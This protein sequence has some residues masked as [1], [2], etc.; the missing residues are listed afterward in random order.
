MMG[1]KLPIAIGPFL[2]SLA[3]AQPAAP[4]DFVELEVCRLSVS[5][6]N[7]VDWRGLYGRG[8]EVFEPAE[9]FEV[10]AV[11]V[12]HEGPPCRYFL[13]ATPLGEGG[14]PALQ[15]PGESLLYDLRRL[16]DG[17]SILSPDYLGSEF[18]RIVGQFG[19]GVQSQVHQIYL[20][21]PASQLVGGGMYGGFAAIRAFRDDPDG[22]SLADEAGIAI[23]APVPSV[24][25]VEPADAAPGVRMMNIDLG[26]LSRPVS[27][28]LGFDIRSNAPVRAHIASQNRGVLAHFAGAPG[29]P[30][31]VSIGG[32]AIDLSLASATVNI[33]HSK[34]LQ[35]LLPMIIIVDGVE[36]AAAGQYSD[37]MTITFIA[38]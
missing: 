24:L 9:N 20:A 28:S 4:Q 30:Y 27:Q 14:S 31:R 22:P 29:I 36:N 23:S 16:P 26:P 17:P 19:A 34:T 33:T 15:G 35:N 11:Q 18:S 13:T 38:D 21:I 12:R 6:D 10:V 25:N 8:Y 37:T 2:A 5:V 3:L 32:T 1:F 7:A